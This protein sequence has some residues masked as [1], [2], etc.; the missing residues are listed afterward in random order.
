M[1]KPA[2]LSLCDLTTVMC[3][4]WA[5]AGFTCYA[6]DVQHPDGETDDGDNII[7][8]GTD[9]MSWLPPR[10]P[11]GFVAAFPPCTNLAVSGARWFR[12]K[13]L[14][15]LIDGLRLVER[16][17]QI[18]EWSGAPWFLENPISVIKS[19]WRDPDHYF[20]PY[21]YGGYEGGEEDGYTKRTCLWTGGGF[22][23]PDP[24]PIELDE[25]THD[26][27]HKAAPSPERSNLRSAT[28]RGFAQAVFEAN[29]GGA[30]RMA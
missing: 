11:I 24:K 6:V 13:G 19:Y 4:P 22:V 8:V 14:S 16:C 9:I 18:A 10:E 7:R 20:D 5:D 27:I 28:P 25:K 15:G 30:M 26:R 2:M 1:N 21:E 3:R 17:A 29:V 12:S 23:M